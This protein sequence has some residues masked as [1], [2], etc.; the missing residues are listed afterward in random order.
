M[1][2]IYKQPNRGKEVEEGISKEI[3]DNESLTWNKNLRE[4]KLIRHEKS[5]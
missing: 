4:V 5:I 1:I 3:T 2:L